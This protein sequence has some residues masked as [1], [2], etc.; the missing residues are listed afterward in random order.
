MFTALAGGFLEISSR[1]DPKVKNDES[2][3]WSEESDDTWFSWRKYL[4]K[5]GDDSSQW[6]DASSHASWFSWQKYLK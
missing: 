5:E 2:S 4:D 1:F 6:S 3:Q